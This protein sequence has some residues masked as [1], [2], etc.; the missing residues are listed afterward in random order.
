MTSNDDAMRHDDFSRTGRGNG[1]GEQTDRRD[2]GRDR[3]MT[4][5]SSATVDRPARSGSGS[6][7]RGYVVPYRY[8]GPG[9]AGWGYYSVMYHGPDEEAEGSERSQGQTQGG[10]QMQAGST[11]QGGGLGSSMGGGLGSS[12]GGGA[13]AGMGSTGMGSETGGSLS[14][15]QGQFR[16]RGPRGYQRS[17]ERI[18]E[19]VC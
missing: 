14:Q 1:S 4:Q 9:Y 18:R 5:G 16:G 12:M 10:S 19:D 7:W 8:T 13:R 6:D 15:S 17:D 11:M 3:R 2:L